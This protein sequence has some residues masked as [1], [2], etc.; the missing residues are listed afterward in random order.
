MLGTYIEGGRPGFAIRRFDDW[1]SVYIGSPGI[2]AEVLRALARLAGA[3]LYIDDGDVIVYANE[4]F[5]GVHT[6]R[7]ADYEIRLKRR[8]DVC[9]AF[10]GRPVARDVDR[11][12]EHIPAQ[13][14][15][16]YC[17]HPDQMK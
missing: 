16:L 1:T 11:F 10:D 15:R 5:I 12:V 7:E 13:T 17:L 6:E 3:H 2:Q 4:S 8:A 9:E 14:T